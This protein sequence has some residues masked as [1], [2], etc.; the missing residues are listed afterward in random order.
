MLTDLL[1][2]LAIVSMHGHIILLVKADICN[3][4]INIL[5]LA[6]WWDLHFLLTLDLLDICIFSFIEITMPISDFI[7][8]LN[9]TNSC[10]SGK[11]FFFVTVVL[12]LY[13]HW[14]VDDYLL[15]NNSIIIVF[16][17]FYL[18]KF[19]WKLLHVKYFDESRIISE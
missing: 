3:A 9:S 7:Q 6:G 18:K 8:D 11:A 10:L 5:S 13:V 1:R 14:A 16:T 4:Y 12:K 19:S 15:L 17:C 2:V